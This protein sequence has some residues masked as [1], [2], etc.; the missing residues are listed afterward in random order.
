MPDALAQFEALVASFA[1]AFTSPT[2]RAFSALVCAWAQRLGRPTA[3]RLMFAAA[4]EAGCAA[5]AFA[6]FFRRS[7]W[8]FD[9]LWRHLVANLVVP[10]LA[11]EGRLAFSC[12][13]T[14]CSKHGRRVAFAGMF[15]DAARSAAGNQVKHRAHCWVV[16]SLQ[17]RLG[18]CNRV[19]GVPVMVRLY[20]K[21][22]DA[23][24]GR[25]F[26]TRQRLALEMARKLAEWL[27]GREIEVVAD[28]AYPSGALVA[29]LAGLARLVSRMRRDAVLYD[30]P[31]RPA[32]RRRG[33]PRQRGERLPTPE[34]LAAQAT[35]WK[36]VKALQYGQVRERLVWTRQ[37]LWWGVAKER[38]VLLVVVRDPEGKQADDFFFTTDLGAGAARV[39]ESFAGR[40]TVEE[41]FRDAKQLFGFSKVMG[42]GEASVE[43]QAPFALLVL[44]LVK[45][46]HIK[47]I[48]LAERPAALP[49]TAQMLAD[50]REAFWGRRINETSMPKA[51]KGII[52]K[53]LR[54]A[55]EAAA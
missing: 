10:A 5:S 40:W 15:L 13:D 14:T 43:R 49:S 54:M 41:D 38:P 55:L 24:P 22:A 52:I 32:K 46:W 48:D 29:G 2:A 42:W 25:P 9:D 26:K 12:D 37:V 35:G 7:R 28:G 6:R 3:R 27:P 23:G 21:K 18:F 53:V 17:V 20:V 36:A 47:C 45:Y 16:M 11:P 39:A 1:F 31:A 19:V 8:D 44:S 33:R 30:L 51:E 34:K 4:G 50:L